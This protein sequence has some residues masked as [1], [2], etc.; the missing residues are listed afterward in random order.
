M[1][2]YSGLLSFSVVFMMFAIF[3]LPV[4]FAGGVDSPLKQSAMGTASEDVI[5]K[6]NL[7]LMIRSSGDPACVKPDTATK[8][9]DAGWEP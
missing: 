9:V 8:L 7:Q 4:A 3:A 5:C 1:N 2:Y 6:N